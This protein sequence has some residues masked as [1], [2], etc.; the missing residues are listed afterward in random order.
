[1]EE[2][3]KEAMGDGNI[4]DIE[5][6]ELFIK[7]HEKF[8]DISL[9]FI[10]RWEKGKIFPD[11]QEIERLRKMGGWEGGEYVSNMENLIK[12]NSSLFEFTG[13]KERIENIVKKRKEISE[14]ITSTFI[15]HEKERLQSSQTNQPTK[16]VNSLENQNQS[17]NNKYSW[18]IIGMGAVIVVLLG[19]IIFLVIRKRKK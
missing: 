5:T 1:M 13:K 7:I 15:Q 12:A 2:E 6:L 10:D 8:Q 16:P 3:Y 17:N 14:K 9:E 18:G 4:K 11:E 19:V